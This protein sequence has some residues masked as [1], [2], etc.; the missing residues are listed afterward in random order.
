ML[1]PAGYRMHPWVAWEQAMLYKQYSAMM[2]GRYSASARQFYT[3][4][5]SLSRAGLMEVG[6]F[7][8]RFR[9]AE[10]LELAGRLE[11]AGFHFSFNPRATVLHYADR[12]FES[13]L[14]NAYDYGIVDAVMMEEQSRQSVRNIVRAGYQGRHT[15]V[16]WLIRACLQF[17]WLASAVKHGLKVGLHV[18]D[19][20][21]A[22]RL[23]R[24]AL[25]GVYALTYYGGLA[26]RLGLPRFDSLVAGR[27]PTD[28]AGTRT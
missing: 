16:R 4:N 23:T 17:A 15:A 26:Q 10:D 25:S 28:A 6:G 12:S 13:W 9:R 2:D 22:K 21:H 5:A 3:G 24:F 27:G 14:R 11:A 7:D 20:V 1:T 8:D 19:I 18:A